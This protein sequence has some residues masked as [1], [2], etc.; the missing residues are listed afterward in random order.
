MDWEGDPLPSCM[1]VKENAAYP[2]RSGQTSSKVV[3]QRC[4]RRLEHAVQKSEDVELA[5]ELALQVI[6]HSRCLCEVHVEC[7]EES[8]LVCNCAIVVVKC[9]AIIIHTRQLQ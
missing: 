4:Q 3:H 1:D 8:W 6:S 5:G 2:G 9:V 7:H